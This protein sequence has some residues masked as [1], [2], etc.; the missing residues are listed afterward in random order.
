MTIMVGHW[1]VDY[2]KDLGVETSFLDVS[3]AE[4]VIGS[5][6]LD[7]LG[8]KVKF[9]R[10]Y[11]TIAA[12]IKTVTIEGNSDSSAGTCFII[13]AKKGK[14]SHALLF[15]LFR[16]EHC[17]LIGANCCPKVDPTKLRALIESLTNEGVFETVQLTI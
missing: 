1:K 7:S 3:S 15:K 8:K 13:Y 4:I 2:Q 11:Q 17:K 14:K 9:N 10:K 6:F 16:D 12:G 5:S